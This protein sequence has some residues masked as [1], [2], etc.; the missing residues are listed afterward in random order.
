MAVESAKV[1]QATA[2][3]AQWNRR[4]SEGSSASCLSRAHQFRQRLDAALRLSG[5]QRN[6]EEE[7][8]QVMLPPAVTRVAGLRITPPDRRGTAET[9]GVAQTL[10]FTVVQCRTRAGEPVTLASENRREGRD[11][12]GGEG[13]V[14]VHVRGRGD[15]QYTGS[16]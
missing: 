10:E 2:I 11:V 13:G 8:R 15:P 9:M 16:K 1:R 4:R 7:V 3:G 5:H 12:S 6:C 14:P